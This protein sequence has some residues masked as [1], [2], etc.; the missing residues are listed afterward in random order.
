MRARTDDED[1]VATR[2]EDLLDHDDPV[3]GKAA[4]SKA[5]LVRLGLVPEDALR[6]AAGT[7][8]RS[9]TP[10][11]P[12]L[13]AFLG[14]PGVGLEIV[15]SSSLPRGSGMGTSS[16][17]AGCV[18]AAVARC[19][20]LDASDDDNDD[21]DRSRLCRLVSDAEQLLTTGGGWQDQIGG[22]AD[23]AFKL[24][25]SAPLTF[26][27]APTVERPLRRRAASHLLPLFREEFD[28]RAVLA[29][30]GTPRLA[31]DLLRRVLRRWTERT[32][33]ITT[34]VSR[35][36]EGAVAAGRS[37]AAD[38]DERDVVATVTAL[39][40]VVRSYWELKRTMAGDGADD[41]V[42]QPDSVASLLSLLY[43]KKE[44][45]GATMCG[46]G[47]GG[48]LLLIAREGRRGADLEEIARANSEGEGFE[49]YRCGTC[50]EGLRVQV[51]H[52]LLYTTT[53]T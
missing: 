43:A 27:S 8:E 19:A 40:G 48:F 9:S 4:L 16:I 44:I 41:N 13:E 29:Y 3:R 12:F 15:S 31:R 33:E 14:A 52:K 51:V 24:A 5:C 49:W 36:V 45:V 6:R 26:P 2:V 7:T 28:R 39:G 53:T 21:G 30:T 32:D 11:A 22:L 34:T 10:L 37:L 25:R 46:A 50:E 1:V 18:L 42:A 38:H 23:G 35:L 20:G 47:G 17:L